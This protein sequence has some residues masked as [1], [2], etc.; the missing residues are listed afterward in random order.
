M[1]TKN[2]QKMIQKDWYQTPILKQKTA[3]KNY[4]SASVA[5]VESRKADNASRFPL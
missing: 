5:S 2:G 1:Q 3:E 4:R